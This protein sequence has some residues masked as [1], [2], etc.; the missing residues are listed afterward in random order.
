MNNNPNQ[1]SCFEAAILF[2]VTL[3]AFSMRLSR[4]LVSRSLNPKLPFCFEAA[5]LFFVTLSRRKKKER[6]RQPGL[7]PGE[8]EDMSN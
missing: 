8:F 3:P 6:L 5:I 2:F 4:H 7:E 1:P